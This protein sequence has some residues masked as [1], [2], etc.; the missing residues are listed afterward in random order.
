MKE[1]NNWVR[2]EFEMESEKQ[3]GDGLRKRLASSV[4]TF[5]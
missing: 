4:F 3:Q 2:N 5:S 1:L